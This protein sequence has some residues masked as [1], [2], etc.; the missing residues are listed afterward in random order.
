[1]KRLTITL[2][3]RFA[4]GRG[5]RH[6]HRRDHNHDRS[7][8]HA[9]HQ[10]GVRHDHH[11]PGRIADQPA[12]RAA[13][14]GLSRDPAAWATTRHMPARS[15]RPPWTVC[16]GPIMC[17]KA[18]ELLAANGFVV[19]GGKDRPV[20][21]GLQP[22]GLSWPASRCSSPPTP[23]TT[24][25]ISPLPRRCATPSNSSCCRSS[26]SSP[27]TLN[28]VAEADAAAFRGT[29]GD[30]GQPG[31]AVQRAAARPARAAR[32]PVC[33]GGGGRAGSHS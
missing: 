19:V 16:C 20:P 10:S 3:V 29:S 21:R 32:G 13:L 30:G 22:R 5:M 26:R 28:E 12:S 9:D 17:P 11:C 23:P 4:V 24:I 33:G 15:P 7:G 31:A 14:R 25:G 1:V 18:R 6:R 27:S 8:D 2:L